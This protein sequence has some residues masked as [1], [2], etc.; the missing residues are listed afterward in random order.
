MK[1]I[2]RKFLLN[3]SLEYLLRATNTN[4]ALYDGLHG[5]YWIQHTITQHYLK[6]TGGW[7]IRVRRIDLE[8]DHGDGLVIE[9]DYVQT[10]KKKICDQSSVEIEEPIS[11][12][13]FEFMASDRSL[14]TPALIKNRHRISYPDTDY[15]WEIDEFLNPEY[16]GL[17]LAE[18][19]LKKVDQVFPIPFWI[20]DEVTNDPTY[21]NVR[22]AHS[23]E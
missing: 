21:R 9:S 6:N 23:L 3:V 17:V 14:T 19:E 5:T 8:V 12:E 10:L 15:V 4:D 22:M 11:K 7:T 13:T 18:I 2:E 20:G 16:A 1:E